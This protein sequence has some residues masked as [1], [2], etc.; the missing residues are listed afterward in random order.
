MTSHASR[1]QHDQILREHARKQRRIVLRSR[2][3]G[4]RSISA[5]PAPATIALAARRKPCCQSRR[6]PWTR[7]HRVPARE[8]PFEPLAG[9]RCLSVAGRRDEHLDPAL[10]F[11]EQASSIAGRSMIRRRLTGCLVAVP[12]PIARS[13]GA[14]KARFRAYLASA[15]LNRRSRDPP[16]RGSAAVSSST[17]QDRGLAREGRRRSGSGTRSEV[18]AGDGLRASGGARRNAP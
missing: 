12:S 7:R 13:A 8:P 11:V 14:A 3:D 17:R 2:G 4:R 1:G 6:R 15:H 18:G 10:A 16:G 5:S 9:Q